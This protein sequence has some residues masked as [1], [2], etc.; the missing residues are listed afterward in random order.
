LFSGPSQLYQRASGL[1][2]LLFDG[3]AALR[4]ALAIEPVEGHTR[5]LGSVTPDT[6][7]LVDRREQGSISGIAELYDFARRLTRLDCLQPAQ[8]PHTVVKGE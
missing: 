5:P 1:C 8:H 3:G 6:G 2:D 7:N 4:P